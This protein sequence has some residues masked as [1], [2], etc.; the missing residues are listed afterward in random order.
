MA[1]NSLKIIEDC[2]IVNAH[3]FPFSPRPN[4]PAAR[5]PQLPREIVKNRAARLR[6]AAAVHRRSWLD[7]L[8]GST[9]RVLIEGPGAGHAENFAPVDIEG[10]SRGDIVDVRISGR[11]ADRLVAA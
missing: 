6:E 9:Q 5:M 4:M 3:V 10:A 1:L 11:S 2:D 7:S 8:V